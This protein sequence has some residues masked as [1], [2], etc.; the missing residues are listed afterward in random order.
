MRGSESD[1]NEIC[2]GTH[3]DPRGAV[4]SGADPA[5]ALETDRPR[6]RSEPE[7]RQEAAARGQGQPPRWT[8]VAIGMNFGGRTSWSSVGQVA[9]TR[10]GEQWRSYQPGRRVAE[11]FGDSWRLVAKHFT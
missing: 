5:R 4:L 10:N 9:T 11:P 2:E 3:A 6:T 8:Q 7:S 1:R